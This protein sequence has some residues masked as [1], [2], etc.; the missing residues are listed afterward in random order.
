MK[1][2]ALSFDDFRRQLADDEVKLRVGPFSL[3][4]GSDLA[5]FAETLHFLYTDFPLL[6]SDDAVE[7]RI[8][9]HRRPGVRRWWRPQVLFYLDDVVPFEPF[10]KALPYPFFEW[11]VNWCVYEHVQEF[12]VLHASVAERNGH[13]VVM[14][15]PPGSGKSTL[16]A[17]LVNRGWRLLSDEFALVDK[18]DGRI[19]PLP[20]PV[21]LKEESVEIIRSFA[22]DAVIG[23]LFRD[24]RKGDIAHMRPPAAAVARAAERVL[25][26][27][28]V[29][30][31]YDPAAT[32]TLAP[33]ARS[34]AFVR[35]S[36]NSFN[37]RVLGEAGFATLAR[38]IDGC[39][40]Y[41]LDFSDLDA[42]IGVLDRLAGGNQ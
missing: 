41:E 23:P 9:I 42:A 38:F 25:P 29:F 14:P 18:G 12:L 40:C 26:A 5:L 22:P 16:C 4:I 33:V 1:V 36:D 13:A 11:G 32:N 27:W 7:F 20:R 2:G 39:S 15:A 35:V 31:R 37:Y 19:A 30:P 3:G 17:A 24:T 8:R 34:A 10:P 6:G 28:L 21:G